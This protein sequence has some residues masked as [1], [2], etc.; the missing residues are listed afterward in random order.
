MYYRIFNTR[1]FKIATWVLGGISVAWA[2]SINMVSIFQ[3]T[4]IEKAWYPLTPGTCIDL[5]A[6]FIA[7]GVPNFA[8]DCAILALPGPR[9]WQ[10]HASKQHRIS[11]IVVFALGTL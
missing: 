8:T 3:C 7:N 9:V 5:K 4:P 1:F 11:V 10:L 2:I 6:S